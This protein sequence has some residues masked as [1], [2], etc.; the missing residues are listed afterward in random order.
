MSIELAMTYLYII[1]SEYNFTKAFLSWVF[2]F[3]LEWFQLYS[4]C[5]CVSHS[6]VSISLWPHGLYSPPGS[7]VHGIFQARILEWVVI[8]FS[9]GSSW[10]R[11][12]TH[13]FSIA[14]G[15]FT[16]WATREAQPKIMDDTKWLLLCKSEKCCKETRI[17]QT[18]KEI[19]FQL[20][21]RQW[22]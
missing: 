14:V 19:F 21:W 15:C 5:V 11:D 12:R 17:E 3:P 18:R 20:Y 1:A 22:T 8:S 13:L 7:S 9:R 4:L 10:P 6:V 16:I 2:N